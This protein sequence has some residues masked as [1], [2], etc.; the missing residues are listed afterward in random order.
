MA[1]RGSMGGIGMLPF[2]GGYADQPAPLMARC[3]VILAVDARLEAE[4]AKAS[5]SR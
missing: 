3:R 4:R 1:M 5:R 2:A